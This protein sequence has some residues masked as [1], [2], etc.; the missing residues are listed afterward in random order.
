MIGNWLR[1]GNGGLVG[2]RLVVD[3]P[4]DGKRLPVAKLDFGFSAAHGQRWNAEALEH[5]CRC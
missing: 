1:I 2:L 4:G 5:E 3:E